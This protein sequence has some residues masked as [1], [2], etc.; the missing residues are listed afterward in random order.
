MVVRMA[1]TLAA[2][3]KNECT[4]L[5]LPNGSAFILKAFKALVDGLPAT[6]Y[7]Y[8]ADSEHTAHCLY[9]FFKLKDRAIHALDGSQG[10]I[11]A[12]FGF[13]SGTTGVHIHAGHRLLRRTLKRGVDSAGNSGVGSRFTIFLNLLRDSATAKHFSLGEVAAKSNNKQDC[14]E[15]LVIELC[16]GGDGVM[17]EEMIF[18]IFW[19]PE[20]YIKEVA[21][22]GHPQHLYAG[23]ATKM[24]EAIFANVSLPYHKLVVL[25][26][27]WFGKY[28]QVARNLKC[29]EE[30]I[31]DATRKDTRLI[32]QTKRIALLQ[33]IIE[34]GG[35]VDTTLPNDLGRGFNL[36]GKIPHAGG[37]LPAKLV[38]ATLLVDKQSTNACRARQALR[39]GRG[40]SGDKSMDQQLYDKT[41]EERSKEWLVGP[42]PWDELEDSAVVSR[43]FG[44][45]QGAK[46]RPIAD[47]SISSINATVTSK[48][49][50][51]ADNVDTICATFLSFVEELSNKGR[52]ASLLSFFLLAGQLV[53]VTWSC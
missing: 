18:G 2:T 35:Y 40:A 28:L 21:A 50:A 23:L 44:W 38:P 30:R 37:R 17:V 3:I 49:Q 11:V 43:R 9:I 22:V 34:D 5:T 12:A 47:Y 39:Y 33:R 16:S 42:L 32:M 15:H 6:L 26:C 41:L 24:K 19:K 52:T 8:G 53:H 4:D 29:K 13:A 27:K 51:T 14:G 1:Q 31:L 10:S 36:V 20:Q 46:L 25:R 48:D 7:E 45:W